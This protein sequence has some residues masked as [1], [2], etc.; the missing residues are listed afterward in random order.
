MSF[1]SRY[2]E[3]DKIF[4]I[5][6]AK[7][8]L[9]FCLEN[10]HKFLVQSSATH[11]PFA[12]KSFDLVTSFDVLVQIF[13]EK[14][15]E[16]AISEMFRVLRPNGTVFVRVAAYNWL[17]SGHDLDLNTQRRYTISE[18]TKKLES[19]GFEVLRISYANCFLFPIAVFRRLILKKLGL[20]D[21]GS[22]VKPLKNETLNSL[23]K[24][25]LHFE[26]KL[27][28]NPKRRF[29]FGLSVICVARKN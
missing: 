22:D 15:D 24:T 5:D 27:L 21:E 16:T 14:S 7:E 17:K 25:V 1:L 29:P 26:A 20:V 4:G 23:L 11:L 9:E 13:G 18:L 10:R 19:E 8:G 6:I 28:K 12:D 2:A 3:K